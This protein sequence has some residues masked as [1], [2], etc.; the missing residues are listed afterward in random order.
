MSSDNSG[1]F[2]N[3]DVSLLV[4]FG[5]TSSHS[6]RVVNS[7]PFFFRL[8]CSEFD[9]SV[10]DGGCGDFVRGDGGTLCVAGDVGTLLFREDEAEFP[11]CEAGDFVRGEGGTL[12][13]AGD[14]GTLLFRGDE[15][16]FPGRGV[17]DFDVA[18]EAVADFL[19]GEG[20]GLTK[21][22]SRGTL[23]LDSPGDLFVSVSF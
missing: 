23:D 17:G 12:C 10:G 21:D 20:E 19:R 16:E 8:R 4:G 3:G 18:G 15:A 1:V 2:S 13:I 9:I 6:L 7:S 14:E 22:R 11:G 5:A